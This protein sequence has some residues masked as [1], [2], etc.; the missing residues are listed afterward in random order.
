MKPASS[1]IR[2]RDWRTR[3]TKFSWTQTTLNAA[4]VS[5]TALDSS[6][7]GQ[8]GRPEKKSSALIGAPKQFQVAIR[9]RSGFEL[10]G[11]LQA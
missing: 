3:S 2:S 7:S 8:K 1:R 5:T 10:I 9:I 4:I 11:F 6:R